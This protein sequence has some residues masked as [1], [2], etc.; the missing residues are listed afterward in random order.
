MNFFKQPV[1]VV[2]FLLLAFSAV[3]E[4]MAQEQRPRVVKTVDSRPTSNPSVNRTVVTTPNSSRPTLSNE[5][6]VVGGQNSQ[7]LVKKTGS[8]RPLMEVPSN[9]APYTGSIVSNML[10]SIRSKYGIPYRLGTTGPNRYDC[11]GFVWAVFNE[12]GIYFERSSARSYWAQF[13]PVSG[14]DR[15]K[16]GTLV[17]LNKLGHVGI[18][19]DEKGFYHASSSKGITYSPFAGYWEKRIVGFR[20]VPVN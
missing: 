20:R 3:T 18:V 10:Q 11:S 4:T 6:V 13:E 2:C 1:V 19:A 5:V 16:F 12:S 7:P 14:D 9:K 8:T 15:Y 17:F